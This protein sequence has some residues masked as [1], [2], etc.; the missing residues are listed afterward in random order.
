MRLNPAKFRRLPAFALAIATTLLFAVMPLSANAQRSAPPG[1]VNFKDTSMLKP[2]PGAKVAI[3]E[4]QDLQCP[5]CAQAFP[6]VHAA[7]AH[8]EIA[9]VERD[10]PLAQHAVLGSY[11]AAI[12]ARYLQDKVSPKVAD[13]YRGAVFASQATIANRDDMRAFTQRFFQSHGLQMPFVADPAGDFAK[14][15]NADRTLGEKLGVMQT[16]TIVVCN[17]HEWVY[18]TDT[19]LLYRTIEQVKSD[20]GTDE[21][22]KMKSAKKAGL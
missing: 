18:V 16:P 10:F 2:P 14:Q 4:F 8:Y 9:L 11:D 3:I 17:A 22:V 12:W 20:A 15:V 21:S 19:S 6:V 5:A 7:V 1:P 13:D